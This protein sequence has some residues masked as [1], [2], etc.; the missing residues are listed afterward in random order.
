VPSAQSTAKTEKTYAR[1]LDTAVTA[2]G[3]STALLDV[4]DPGITTG[5]LDDPRPVGGGVVAAIMTWSVSSIPSRG[6]AA[7]P[8]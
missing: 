2:L 8:S 5:G 7:G 1:E 3:S 4:K 6:I